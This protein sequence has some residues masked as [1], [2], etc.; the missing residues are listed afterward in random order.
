MAA[1]YLTNVPRLKG[2][3]NF[4]EWSFAIENFMILEGLKG[5]IEGKE[6]DEEKIAKAKA[7]IVLTIDTSLYVHIK[8]V[9][10]AQELWNKLKAMFDDKVISRDVTVLEDLESDK[11]LQVEISSGIFNCNEIPVLLD[12]VGATEEEIHEEEM[13]EEEIHEEDINDDD[14][15]PRCEIVNRGDAIRKSSRPPTPKFFEEYTTFMATN[16]ESKLTVSEEN[17]ITVKEALFTEGRGRL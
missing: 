10:T 1:S 4:D 8:D 13:H 15:I 11:E 7:K 2:R 12:P 17:P 14:Y 9:T 16:Q 5:C 3:E 6:N